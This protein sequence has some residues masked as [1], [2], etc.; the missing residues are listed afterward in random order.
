M[1]ATIRG[2]PRE[3]IVAVAVWTVLCFLI[4]LVRIG[5]AFAA[6]RAGP[7]SSWLAEA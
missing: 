4:H 2:A 1:V 7:L 5:Q 6:R 3:G